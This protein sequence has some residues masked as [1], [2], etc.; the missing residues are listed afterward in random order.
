MACGQDRDIRELRQEYAELKQVNANLE[1][2]IRENFQ[3]LSSIAS[4][5]H[6]F[7]TFAL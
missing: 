3:V 6:L 4:L 5:N 1:R 2:Q 7:K